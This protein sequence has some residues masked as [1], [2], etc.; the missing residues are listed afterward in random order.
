MCV[1]SVLV[2]LDDELGPGYQ[3]TGSRTCL[4]WQVQPTR[5][6]VA[7]DH[8]ARTITN[9]LSHTTPPPPPPLSPTPSQHHHPATP[10]PHSERSPDSQSQHPGNY[11]TS[12][13]SQATPPPAP[14]AQRVPPPRWVRGTGR[15]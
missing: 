12:S 4:I 2:A 1:T 8:F 15:G 11:P 14:S 6:L 3:W 13:I 10:A 5:A 9:T 7:S